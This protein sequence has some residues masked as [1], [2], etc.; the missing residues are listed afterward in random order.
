MTPG[1]PEGRDNGF[2]SSRKHQYTLWGPL[3]LP[4]CG[5]GG[6]GVELPAR[7]VDY[8]FSFGFV[9]K[10]EWKYNSASAI[11]G[12]SRLED[13]TA[14]G[15]FLGLCDQ[16]CSYKHMSDFGRLRSYG[17]FLIPVHAPV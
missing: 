2:F 8:Y 15:N 1:F 9:I 6:G 7:E 5:K 13:I 12:V 4:V 11:Q 17:D 3:N 16:K 14:A 10:N